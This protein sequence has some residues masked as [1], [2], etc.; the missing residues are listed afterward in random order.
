MLSLGAGNRDRPPNMALLE[1]PHKKKRKL[2]ANA[3]G[4]S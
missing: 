1:F 4:K 2:A 3:G